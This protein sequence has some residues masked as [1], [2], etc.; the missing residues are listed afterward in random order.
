RS[1]PL[2]PGAGEAGDPG[3]QLGVLGAQA[4]DLRVGGRAGAARF[5][6]PGPARPPAR[7]GHGRP[8]RAPPPYEPTS[9]SRAMPT[10]THPQ[11][12]TP[13]IGAW[14]RVQASAV[15]GRNRKPRRGTTT[16]LS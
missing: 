10:T 8:A 16:L 15:H 5:A 6:G 7:R 14:A 2:G 4:L 3:P 1:A 12:V 11:P 13:M 9:V